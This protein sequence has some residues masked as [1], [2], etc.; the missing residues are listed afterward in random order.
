M[1]PLVGEVVA[2]VLGKERARSRAICA[3]ALALIGLYSFA[4]A[5]A[6][7]SMLGDPVRLEA[8]RASIPAMIA[9]GAFARVGHAS[10]ALALLAP[11][12]SLLMADP[13][14]W[15]AG[16]LWGPEVAARLAGRGSRGRRRADR[17]VRA[18]E[19]YGSGAVVV[20]YLL[21]IPTVLMYAAAGWTGMRLRRFLLLDLAGTSLWVALVVGLGYTIG[22]SAVHITHAIT[23]Y[24][25]LV[26]LAMVV[27]VLVASA[28]HMRRLRTSSARPAFPSAATRAHINETGRAE[29]AE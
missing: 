29:L 11:L 15:W 5:P 22:R 3:A 18:L 24:G 8:L 10:L 1:V 20:A 16:R 23:R 28:L 26:T 4:F 21:P 19:R 14:V 27:I 25:L 17:A 7:P 6:V 12:P 2:A 13:F 9:G